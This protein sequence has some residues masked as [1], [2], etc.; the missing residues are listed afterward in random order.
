MILKNRKKLNCAGSTL[1][2]TMVAITIIL[3]AIIGTS[4]FRYH[5]AL[6]SRKANALVEASAIALLL[7]ESWLGIQGDVNYNPVSHF[8]TEIN[9][10]S[11]S[12][13]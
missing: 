9:I 8:S 13:S 2:G 11:N 5:A 12:Q 3:L 4:N 6:D 7:S 1:I 10:S